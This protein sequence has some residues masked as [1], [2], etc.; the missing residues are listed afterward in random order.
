MH[1]PLRRGLDTITPMQ[2]KL[3]NADPRAHVVRAYH[4]MPADHALRSIERRWLKVARISEV[5]DPFELFALRCLKRPLR[6]VLKDFK[7]THDSQ[8]GLLCFSRHWRN[9][10]LWSHY[11]DRHRGICLGFDIDRNIG[12]RGVMEVQYEPNKVRL[13][14]DDTPDPKT[15]PESIQDLLFVTKFRTGAMNKSYGSW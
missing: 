14:S 5:N 6:R 1:V 7:A 2:V 12:V 8:V 4:L 15:I 11:A 10:V 9:P 13:D 3:K